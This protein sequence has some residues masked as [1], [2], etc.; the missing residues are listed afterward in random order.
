MSMG[1]INKS[2]L[3]VNG[4]EEADIS[5]IFRSQIMK[6]DQIIMRKMKSCLLSVGIS[7]I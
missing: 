3:I 1:N 2:N 6:I 4:V 5:D 7:L